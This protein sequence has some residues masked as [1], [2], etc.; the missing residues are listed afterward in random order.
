[1]NGRRGVGAVALLILL[2]AAQPADASGASLVSPLGGGPHPFGKATWVA[3][4]PGE[5][6][7]LAADRTGAVVVLQGGPAGDGDVLGVDTG[8]R[9]TW[10]QHIADAVDID[11]V[12]DDAIVVVPGRTHVTAL[13]RTTG[14]Q[15]WQQ[16]VQQ[17]TVGLTLQSG[18]A[19][20][21]DTSG[22]LHA[23]D[24]GSGAPRWKV[25]YP[26]EVDDE[27]LVDAVGLVVAVWVSPDARTVRALDTTT[28]A[29]RW[30]VPIA[31]FAAAPTLLNGSV[32]VA[33]GDGHFHAQVRALDVT[34]GATRWTTTVP[35][36]F[37]S[38]IHPATDGHDLAIV[39]HFGLVTMLD[40]PTGKVRWQ[41]RLGE[42]IFDAHLALVGRGVVIDERFFDVVVL[43]R[44]SGRL[45]AR[46]AH[47]GR[48]GIPLFMAPAPWAPA[49]S[50]L[51]AWR[52]A[53]PPRLELRASP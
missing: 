26:G 46:R 13:D 34:S 20:V 27:P 47:H 41:V 49:P 50:F 21:G 22:V 12:I 28:G 31:G 3:G 17:A 5:P 15:R 32:Y 44:G 23:F 48:G 37:Q 6:W 43:E 35:A 4:L 24:A 11:P 45:L 19:Y 7:G 51:L 30:A 38:G 39:D 10:R 1:M 8:G 9:L 14:K 18:T 53:D 25:A 36:S 40:A 2:T 29:L 33:E 42:G 52:L 16:P